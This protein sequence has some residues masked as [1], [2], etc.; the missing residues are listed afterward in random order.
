MDTLSAGRSR[1]A[2]DVPM[3]E[4]R[5]EPR[6]IKLAVV[7]VGYWG[8]NLLR[9]AS[10]LEDVEVA[11]ICDLVPERLAALK[12]RN[13]YVTTTTRIEDV[14]TDPTIDGVI[15]ASPIVTHHELAL[16]CLGAGKH[17]FVE[18]PMAQ[19]SAQCLDLI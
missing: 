19:T 1:A 17:V 10:E 4:P 13:P 16:R 3:Y 14:L 18:K 11:V 6:P 9:A 15:L 8:P 2:R 5:M 12:K 7:G